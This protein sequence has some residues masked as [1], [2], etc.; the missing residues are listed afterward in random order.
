VSRRKDYG[1]VQLATFLGLE[2]WQ[3]SRARQ[4]ELIPGPDRPRGRWSEQ[5]AQDARDRIGVIVLAVGAIPDLG[6]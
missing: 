1:P 3:F 5:I 2:P 4:A 6:L